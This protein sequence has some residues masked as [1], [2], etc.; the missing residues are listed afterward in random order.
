[1]WSA[2]AWYATEGAAEYDWKGRE[3]SDS[4]ATPVNSVHLKSFAS[5]ISLF[6]VRNMK[7]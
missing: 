5:L 6:W 3:A 4:R 2:V 7:P 1:M